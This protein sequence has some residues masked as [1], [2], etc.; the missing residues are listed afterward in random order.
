MHSPKSITVFN[1]RS[2]R[3]AT[4]LVEFTNAEEAGEV[5]ITCNHVPINEI[6]GKPPYILKLAFSD[7]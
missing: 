5:L 2:E 1:T 4:G 6:S 3:S 7:V